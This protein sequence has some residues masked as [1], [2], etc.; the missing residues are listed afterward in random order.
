MVRNPKDAEARA[1]PT[2]P[3]EKAYVANHLDLWLAIF[4]PL[5][6]PERGDE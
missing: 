3:S 5:L 6:L 2:S 4:I 1:K